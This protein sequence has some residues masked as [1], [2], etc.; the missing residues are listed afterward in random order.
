VRWRTDAVCL[1]DANPGMPSTKPTAQT[2][3]KMPKKRLL[4]VAVSEILGPA[5]PSSA[6]ES[7]TPPQVTRDADAQDFPEGHEDPAQ[8]AELERQQDA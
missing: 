4:C 8:S 5:D 1:T 3:K 2:V 6:P 7:S